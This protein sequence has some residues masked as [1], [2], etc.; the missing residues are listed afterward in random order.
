[1][2]DDLNQSSRITEVDKDEA[3]VISAPV[4][5][6]GDGDVLAGVVG[7]G[8]AAVDGLQHGGSS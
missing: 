5:P 4:H 6:S 8:Q 7:A 3:A 1:M 2:E